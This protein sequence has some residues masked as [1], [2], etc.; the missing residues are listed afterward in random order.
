M[1][2]CI[3]LVTFI[4]RDGYDAYFGRYEGTGMIV[5]MDAAIDPRVRA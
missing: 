5:D 2:F 1:N 4:L 3:F